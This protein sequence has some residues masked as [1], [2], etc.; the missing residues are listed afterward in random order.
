MGWGVR[1]SDDIGHILVWG[2]SRHGRCSRE[3]TGGFEMCVPDGVNTRS[4]AGFGCE[5]FE[6]V[7]YTGFVDGDCLRDLSPG[8]RTGDGKFDGEAF[9]GG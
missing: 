3:V 7:I 2:V 6:G 8:R 5:S 9:L 4:L 1:S